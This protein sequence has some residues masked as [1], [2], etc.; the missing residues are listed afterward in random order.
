MQKIKTAIT[1]A[2][3]FIY[4]QFEKLPKPVKSMVYA[5]ISSI[6]MN[7]VMILNGVGSWEAVKASIVAFCVTY[8]TYMSNYFLKKQE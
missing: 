6:C 3:V 8:L 1:A 2:R 4:N 5:L 7:L